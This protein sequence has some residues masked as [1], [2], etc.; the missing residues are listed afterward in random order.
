MVVG[1]HLTYRAVITF[2]PTVAGAT[3]QLLTLLNVAG[4]SP[5]ARALLIVLIAS[6]EEVL[7]RGLLPTSGAAGS[8][9]PHWPSRRELAQIVVFA[10]VYAFTTLP[11]GSA[12]LLLCAFACGSLWGLMRVATGSLVVPLLAHVLWDLGVLLIWPLTAQLP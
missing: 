1:T 7:F 12:L 10:A 6:C 8:G 5:A 4:F 9:L 3:R 11:L 2:A